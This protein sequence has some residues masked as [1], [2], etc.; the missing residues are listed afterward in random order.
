MPPH[1]HRAFALVAAFALAGPPAPSEAATISL[2]TR[3]VGF[4]SPAGS[5]PAGPTSAGDDF[6]RILP[7]GR[8]V[9]PAG[10]SVVV[11]MNALG[12]AL[13]PDG[14]FAVV[15]NDDERQGKLHSALDPQTTGGY[16]LCVVDTATMTVVSR[17][18]NPGQTF[19]AGVVAL[20]DPAEPARTLVLASGP[21]NDVYA[22]DL[23]PSG[24]LTPDAHPVIAIP[25]PADARFANAGHSFPG[26]LV[27][28]ADRSRAYVVDNLGNDVAQIDTATRTLTGT[29]IP[30]GFFPFGAALTTQGLLVANEGLTAYGVLAAPAVA[31]PFANVQPD[32]A[33]ASSLT[34]VPPYADGSLRPDTTPIALDRPPDG[35]RAVGGAHPVAIAALR[36]RP[37]AFVA[38]G[39]VDRVATVSL[40]PVGLAGLPAV[41]RAVGP[42]GRNP[43]RSRFRRTRSGCTSRSPESTRLRCSTRRTPCIRIASASFRPVGIPTRSRFPATGG[44][45][46]LPMRKGSRRTAGSSAIR[47]HT[48]MRPVASRKCPPTATPSGRRWNGSIYNRSIYARARR[49][50]SRICA[51]SSRCGRTRSCRNASRHPEATRSNTSS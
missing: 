9:H 49:T 51:R 25:G 34:L 28:S 31:P 2:P 21:S 5:R 20:P 47:R 30:V 48:S 37:Y 11:G 6:G 36:S 16:S 15:S 41:P 32:E 18:A 29:P 23:D 10:T 22:F 24:A 14:R 43:R 44:I 3:P 1:P 19:F 33:R 46:T 7:S 26:T 40:E 12:F 17:Y 27:L 8:I 45:S 4:S 42:T 50:R 39:N 38:L 13:T 35:V